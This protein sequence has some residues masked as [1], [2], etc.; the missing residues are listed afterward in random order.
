MGCDK[1]ALNCSK[2]YTD[3]ENKYIFPYGRL[4]SLLLLLALYILTKTLEKWINEWLNKWINNERFADNHLQ[5]VVEF[6]F[7]DKETKWRTDSGAQ[8]AVW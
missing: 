7:S 1:D 2:V 6:I 3:D 4:F 8:K 5:E